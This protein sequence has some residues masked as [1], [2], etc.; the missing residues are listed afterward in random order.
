MIYKY[1]VDDYISVNS[2]LEALKEKTQSESLEDEKEN[3]IFFGEINDNS[4]T[5]VAIHECYPIDLKFTVEGEKIYMDYCMS[6]AP[7]SKQSFKFGFM[8][9]L[10]FLGITLA[11]IFSPK[12]ENIPLYLRILPLGIFILPFLKFG[13]FKNYL[14]KWKY[15]FTSQSIKI[16]KLEKI[17]N[18]RL[19]E[20]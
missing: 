17:L 11:G 16:Q 8:V 12:F 20:I 1:K 6:T 19:K 3:P 9:P 2:F 10:L 14:D 13:L 7:F 4:F 15:T 18:V 5:I